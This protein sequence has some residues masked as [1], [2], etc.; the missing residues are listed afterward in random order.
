MRKMTQTYFLG[1]STIF[2][3]PDEYY[4]GY[5]SSR[6]EHMYDDRDFYDGK[7]IALEKYVTYIYNDKATWR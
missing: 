5:N 3:T 4:F 6:I 1:N 2:V 7:E